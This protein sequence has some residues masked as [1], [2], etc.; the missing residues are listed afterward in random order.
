[1]SPLPVAEQQDVLARYASGAARVTA[2]LRLPLLALLS[3][4]GW[5]VPVEHFHADAF[6]LVLAAYAAWSTAWLLVPARAAAR[7]WTSWMTTAVDV[8]ALAGLAAASGGSGS[9]LQ[10]VFFL[11]PIVLAFQYRPALTAAVGV[12]TSVGYLVVSLQTPAYAG[13][14]AAPV[15]WLHFG[16]LLWLA[17]ATTGLSV[18]LV[19]RSAAV[20][21]LLDARQRL[22]ADALTAEERE[23]RRIA[24]TLHDGPLQ[25]VLAARM[26]VEGARDRHEGE[27]LARAEDLLRGAAGELRAAVTV[28]HPQVLGR[29]G[30]GPAVRELAGQQARRG[31]LELD[32]HVDDV[33]PHETDDLLYGVARELLTN[34]VKHGRATQVCVRLDRA[35]DGRR[36][37][38]ADDGVGFDTGVEVHRLREGHIGL[39]SQRLRVATAGG[40]L[41]LA[42]AR[43]EGTRVTVEVPA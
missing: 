39:A 37:V 16:F 4:L 6:R 3:L 21:G 32:L 24:E 14:T 23:R 15:V 30:L 31:R 1:M 40:R 43:G 25:S 27:G 28:L 41:T 5:A 33:E 29:L 10:P 19:R 13:G 7:P 2:G 36:L 26:D 18:L 12:A 42:T 38:V 20:L 11:L 34:V 22:V 9:L 8:V 17:A 35:A